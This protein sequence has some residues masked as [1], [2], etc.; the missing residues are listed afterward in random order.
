MVG[1]CRHLEGRSLIPLN[2]DRGPK[3]G[4]PLHVLP[5][6]VVKF[7]CSRSLQHFAVVGGDAFF[8]NF[9]FERPQVG[10]LKSGNLKWSG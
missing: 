3:I 6:K 2:Y 10:K 1:L 4:P 8:F 7:G 5:T 9:F